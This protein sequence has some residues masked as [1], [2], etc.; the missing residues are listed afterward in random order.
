MIFKEPKFKVGDKVYH[1][2]I[3]ED[4]ALVIDVVYY[5]LTDRHVYLLGV[6]WDGEYTCEEHEI[7]QE[8]EL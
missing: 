8:K 5:Y 4:Q 2:N 3:P 1:V 6:G 7:T